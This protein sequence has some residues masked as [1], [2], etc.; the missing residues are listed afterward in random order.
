MELVTAETSSEE[1]LRRRTREVCQLLRG[2][3]CSAGGHLYFPSIFIDISQL[4]KDTLG[5]LFCCRRSTWPLC[6]F[7][8][9]ALVKGPVWLPW[10]TIWRLG[11]PSI[12]FCG[13]SR[14]E[15]KELTYSYCGLCQRMWFCSLLWGSVPLNG[16]FK[17]QN[18]TTLHPNAIYIFISILFPSLCL[19]ASLS[20]ICL[21]GHLSCWTM[22]SFKEGTVK[23]LTSPEP[24]TKEVCSIHI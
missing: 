2:W 24:T 1:L 14:V 6:H 22:S 8:S 20:A 19:H 9:L 12:L 7:F 5:H 15:E 4:L 23:I 10:T 11:I 13:R 16:I 3:R 18:P 21:H 17:R